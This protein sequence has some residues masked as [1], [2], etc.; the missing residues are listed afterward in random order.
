MRWWRRE[1]RSKLRDADWIRVK[2]MAQLQ[3]KVPD[4]LSHALPGFLPPGR[5]AAPPVGILLDVF[6]CQYRLKGTT[7]QVQFDDIAGGECLLRQVRE[8]Q[9]VDHP[10]ACDPN[11]TLLFPCRMGGDDHAARR[12]FGSYRDL[13][14]IVE[15]A[16][17]LAFGTLL[18]L[19]R[20]KMQPRLDQRM[21]KHAVLF[22]A[23]HKR[24]TGYIGEHGSGAIL[25][26]EPQQRARRFE[27]IRRE[28]ATNGCK[29]LAQFLPVAS[30]P[31]VAKTAEPVIAVRL[32]DDGPCP[33][34]LPALASPVARGADVI[35]PATGRGKFISLR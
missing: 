35:Q 11:R 33:H 27:L 22:A 19:I 14:A 24:E 16:D 9:F 18:D 4:P 3:A 10:C 2:V 28:I 7:M 32:A 26:V 23:G 12:S 31:A 6:V 34:H 21:V 20:W 15:A 30:V 1:S 17:H 13:G 5:V 25:A 29:S 8:E